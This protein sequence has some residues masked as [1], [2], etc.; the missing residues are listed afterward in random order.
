MS[1]RIRPRRP[2]L[3]IALAVFFA[4]LLCAAKQKPEEFKEGF[5]ALD[6][7]HWKEAVTFLQ[8]ALEES[9]EADGQRTRIYGGR[10][11]RYYPYYYLGKALYNLGCYEAAL[12]KFE[13]SLQEGAIEGKEHDQL[14]T[15]KDECEEKL[16][17]DPGGSESDPCSLDTSEG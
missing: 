7:E 11:E 2:L 17:E 9:P 4:P 14:L 8:L 1:T 16:R 5:K 12:E 15:F 3:I 6:R 10:F 13:K